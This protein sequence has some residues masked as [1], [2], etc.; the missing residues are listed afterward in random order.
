M[1]SSRD[2]T[3][4]GRRSLLLFRSDL[5]SALIYSAFPALY[6]EP[7]RCFGETLLGIGVDYVPYV[8]VE[9]SKQ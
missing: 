4:G 8:A 3:C 1:L 7:H 5:S 6:V 9:C 2:G